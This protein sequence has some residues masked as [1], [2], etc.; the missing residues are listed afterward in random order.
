MRAILTIT[1][2]LFLVPCLTLD[3]QKKWTLEECFTYAL[4]NN[5][6][7]KRQALQTD[8]AKNNLKQSKIELFP[9]LGAGFDHQFNSGKALNQ[10][11][12]TW[13][14]KSFS[15]GSLV[16]QSQLNLFNGFRDWNNIKYNQLN[17]EVNMAKLEKAKNDLALNIAA[18]YLQVLY[19][20]ELLE[21][22]KGQ[23][24]ITTLEVEKFS[25]LVE[26]GNAARGSLFEI[27]AQAAL[28]KVNVTTARNNLNISLIN[29][30]QMLD[31][32]T[33]K[34][35]TIA[36]PAELQ[37]SD[38]TLPDSVDVIYSDAAATMPEIKSAEFQMKSTEKFLAMEKG[39]LAPTLSLTA[40][41][42]SRYNELAPNP[43]NPAQTYSYSS[44]IK[45][46]Q[47]KQLGF[48]ISV[49]IFT[50]WSTRT[51]INNAKINYLDSK[52]NYSLSLQ[53]LYKDIQQ[54][55]ADAK[56]ALEN[57][58]SRNES[59]IASEENY[60][61]NQQKFDVGIINSVDY[62]IAKNNFAKAQS[63][64]LQAKYQFIFKTKILDFY[65]GK[66]ITL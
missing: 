8:I 55:H 44:Q 1:F 43:I 40:S 62:N 9:N 22:A 13:Q 5:I 15:Q 53:V 21:I 23:L 11:T 60:K 65:R 34:N 59:V 46:N 52:L 27:Q 4:E 2:L 37:V 29:M 3:A 54:A 35:F 18:N 10:D 12:Y 38:L 47:Y 20:K 30:A 6:Q 61:Y 17:L 32:D 58:N 14:D 33:I 41:Y 57:F 64:L 66:R 63:D 16:I 45:D 36:D 19:N 31:L 28:D 26:V 56:A 48:N 42:S 49:P 39:V 51:R 7:L 50:K 25:K 24:Q